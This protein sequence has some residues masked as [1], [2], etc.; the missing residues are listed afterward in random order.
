MQRSPTV[1]FRADAD[2]RIGGGHVM[3]CLTLAVAFGRA[4]WRCAVAAGA[5]SAT[6]VPALAQSGLEVLEAG[7]GATADARQILAY[8]GAKVDLLVIDHPDWTAVEEEAIAPA[9]AASMAIDGLGRRHV[10]DLWLDPN[11]GRRLADL[12]SKA[13]P[14]CEILLGPQFMPIAAPVAAIRA[15]SLSARRNRDFRVA[16][17]L[18]NFGAGDQIVAFDVAL[19]GIAASG[20]RYQ[21]TVVAGT[22]ASKC[23]EL[24]AQ[25]D[26][27]CQILV[28]TDRMDELMLS[29]DLMIAAAGISAWERCCAGLP[30]LI[31]TVADNQLDT[32]R[33]LNEQGAALYVGP[34]DHVQPGQIA[35]ALVRLTDAPDQLAQMSNRAA[36]EIDGGGAARVVAAVESFIER[37]RPGL[38]L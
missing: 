27:D 5:K 33:Y 12:R 34:T 3:R 36:A 14:H 6:T 2:P 9:G 4:G 30:C 37:T 7:G 22:S 11:P 15:R 25:L 26:L 19:R 23:R 28:W 38:G 31:L 29:A 24:A 35:S 8:F 17:I 1:V 13:A 10:T 16:H 21:T 32:A 18:I 20:R